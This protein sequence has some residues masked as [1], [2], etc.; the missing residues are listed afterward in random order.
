MAD[1]LT[2]PH[3][4]QVLRFKSRMVLLPGQR[5]FPSPFDGQRRFVLSFYPLDHTIG[6]FEPKQPNSGIK[7]GTFL[8]RTK[9]WKAGSG[10]MELVGCEDMQ[11][12]P[13]HNHLLIRS[14]SLH[15]LSP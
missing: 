12:G 13:L 15:L 11:V 8:E 4:S 1:P 9:V 2:R 6:V 5:E 7:G 10:Q 3:L 14:S